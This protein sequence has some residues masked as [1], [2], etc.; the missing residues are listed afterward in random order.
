MTVE[1]IKAAISQLSPQ[2]V[3]EIAAFMARHRPYDKEWLEREA[4]K[5]D[6]AEERAMAEEGMI[7]ATNA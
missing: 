4:A 1:E 7:K 3:T 5:L 2:E 6:P